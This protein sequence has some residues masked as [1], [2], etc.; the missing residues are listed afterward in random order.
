[1]VNFTYWLERF[2]DSI[3]NVHIHRVQLWRK[4][5]P[6]SRHSAS[7]HHWHSKFDGRWRRASN[8]ALWSSGQGC[9]N[10][11]PWRCYRVYS[12]IASM[13]CQSLHQSMCCDI[14]SSQALLCQSLSLPYFYP[15][16][17]NL[18][19]SKS[20]VLLYLIMIQ[21]LSALSNYPET[22]SLVGFRVTRPLCLAKK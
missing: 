17:N 12:S 8:P 6:H 14:I 1:M 20:T 10:P 11:W 22:S 2:L 13:W 9:S 21:G 5:L 7:L 4:D 15:N 16:C 19:L 18:L 3:C